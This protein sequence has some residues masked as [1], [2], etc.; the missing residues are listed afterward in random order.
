MREGSSQRAVFDLA[1]DEGSQAPLIPATAAER[2]DLI[3]AECR[4]HAELDTPLK[5]TIRA[6]RLLQPSRS[7]PVDRRFSLRW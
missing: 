6:L 2:R 5:F 1:T 7:E 4:P 3:V